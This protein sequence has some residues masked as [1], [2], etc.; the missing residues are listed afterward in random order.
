M[1]LLSEGYSYPLSGRAINRATGVGLAAKYT[2]VVELADLLGNKW[3]NY[4]GI[5]TTAG[6]LSAEQSQQAVTLLVTKKETV[7]GL[8]S[9][10]RVKGLFRATGSFLYTTA[11]IALQGE[12]V[13]LDDDGVPSYFWVI[14]D[15]TVG[16]RQFAK[17]QFNRKTEYSTTM[18]FTQRSA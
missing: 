7:S 1:P 2:V 9:T 8:T 11:P 5:T 15:A 13:L 10:F 12:A 6:A 18:G 14:T 3:T 17:A 16:T 4:S